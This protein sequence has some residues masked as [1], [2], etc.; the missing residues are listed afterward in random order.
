MAEEVKELDPS[1]DSEIKDQDEHAQ[2]SSAESETEEDLLSVVQDAMQPSED[3]DSQSDEEYEDDDDDGEY[4]DSELAAD[5]AD[6]SFEDVPF[7]KHPRFKEVIDQRNKYREGAE[8]YEQITGFLAQNN[9]SAEEAAQGF[10]IMAL[11]KNDPAAALDA[12]SPFVQQLEYSLALQC[13][14]IFSLRSK[15]GI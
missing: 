9:L 8:Q 14:A 10:Q 6:D 5:D 12:L 1:P 3:A 11:M 7:H 4:S 2:S 13:L 15:M